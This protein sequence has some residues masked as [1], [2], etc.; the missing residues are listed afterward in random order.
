MSP[1]PLDL[2]KLLSI[3]HIENY[4]RFDIS[5]DGTRLAFS[6]NKTGNWEIYFLNLMNAGSIQQ[7]TDGPG[8][9]MAPR[10]SSRGA[11]AYLLDPDGGENFD[12]YRFDPLTGLHTNLTPHSDEAIQPGYAWSPDGMQVAFCS[13]RS[14]CFS[15]YVMPVTGEPVH[16]VQDLPLHAD[17]VQWSGDSRWLSV[18][19]EASGQD[20]ETWILPLQGGQPHPVA[21]SGKP[22]NA[23]EPDWIPGGSKLA[24]AS[25]ANGS[26][27]IGIYDV[28]TEE[29]IW[30]TS[31]EG[32][33]GKPRWSPDGTKLVYQLRKGP[34]TFLEVLNLRSGS[35]ETLQPEPGICDLPAF[36]PNQEKVVF[37]FENPRFP[38]D[39][40]QASL[41]KPVPRQLTQSLPPYV[42]IDR[43]ELPEE[44][45]YPSPDGEKVP[46]LLYRQKRKGTG[47]DGEE[48]K[49]AVVW[50]HGGPNWLSEMS[51]DPTIQAMIGRG[52]TVLAPNYRGS[53]GYGRR[54][55]L[56]NRFDLGG[57]D[58]EDVDA[59]A[60]FLVREGYADADRV[61]VTGRSYGGYLTMV[62]LIK[63]PRRWAAGSAVVPFLNWFTGHANSRAD[64]QHWDL[65]NFGDPEKD[66]ELFYERSPFY[67]LDRISAP[68]Q[69]ICGGNDPRCPASESIAALKNLD[70]LGKSCELILFE[71]E[72][73]R[74]LKTE[75]RVRAE[76]RREEFLASALES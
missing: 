73:H 14:G 12:L 36:T 47:S 66:R 38:P 48:G 37:L 68:V 19:Y 67:F 35:R 76:L 7:I 41:I 56:S 58:V 6:W 61:A 11:L 16:L 20:H 31:G 8:A 72:G 25:D 51:W 43:F 60:D 69:L 49:P 64:L 70:E 50:I 63:D 2:E 34:Q 75:N 26:F 65:E 71:D 28:D 32:D 40:W 17:S 54:W 45:Q 46:A 3:P 9:K 13:N 62:C 22:V 1:N 59:G 24:F 29:V 53:I 23:V 10:W 21:I 52:W 55:Q 18:C 30:V 33:K 39:L 15:P 74:F 27:E 44:I 4:F 42:P 5:P 57:K